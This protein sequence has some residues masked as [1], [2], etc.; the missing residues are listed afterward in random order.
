MRDLPKKFMIL[1]AE[2]YTLTE[3]QNKHR[4]NTLRSCLRIMGVNF[5]Q[6]T[7]VYKGTK[8]ISFLCDV[9]N[10]DVQ[11]TI[12]T[13]AFDVFGQE[14]VLHKEYDGFCEL[15]Y[16]DASVDYLGK[17]RQVSEI[18]ASELDAYT[19]LNDNTIITVG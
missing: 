18:E 4:T 5:E 15:L 13:L 10:I 11:E 2:Y 3:E 8:E 17:I 12:Q 7:G 16:K 14:S 19:I 6:V 1:S 9:S